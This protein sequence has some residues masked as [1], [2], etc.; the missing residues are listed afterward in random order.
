MSIRKRLVSSML[1]LACGLSTIALPIGEGLLVSAVSIDDA[2]S[3]T[4]EDIKATQ[5]FLMNYGY[6]GLGNVKDMNGDGVVNVIDLSL[7]KRAYLNSGAVTLSHFW[8]DRTDIYLDGETTVTFTVEVTSSNPLGNDAVA[9]YDENDDFIA[10]M[11]DD[12]EN[13]DWEANDGVYSAQVVVSSS[14]IALVSFY[15]ATAN[16]KSNAYELNFYRDFTDEEVEVFN[17]VNENITDV[18]FEDAKK[19]IESSSDVGGYAISEDS[20]LIYYVTT[21]GIPG[22][23]CNFSGWTAG[24]SSSNNAAD[25]NI[26]SMASSEA[27]AE[28]SLERKTVNEF[29]SYELNQNYA[30]INNDAINVQLE[31]LKTQVKATIDE[32]KDEEKHV[33]NAFRPAH[34]DKTGVFVFRP[35]RGEESAGMARDE[36]KFA[37]EMISYAFTGDESCDV[38]DDGDA[39]LDTL[40]TL[41]FHNYGTI[42]IE[43]HGTYLDGDYDT[44]KDIGW[45]I[46][47]NNMPNPI[48]QIQEK[49]FQYKNRFYNKIIPAGTDAFVCHGGS[50]ISESADILAGRVIPS[51]SGG[52]Q[53]YLV[54]GK[55]FSNNSECFSK[56]CFDETFWFLGYCDSMKK[57]GNDKTNAGIQKVNGY[58]DYMKAYGKPVHIGTEI[59]HLGAQCI[60]GYNETVNIAYR[61]KTM[62]EFVV[63][64]LLLKADSAKKSYESVG[65]TLGLID[66]YEAKN[67]NSCKFVLQG[68]PEYRLVN[69]YTIIYGRVHEQYSDEPAFE[70]MSRAARPNNYFMADASVDLYQYLPD[71]TPVRED[72]NPHYDNIVDEGTTY[73]WVSADAENRQYYAFEVPIGKVMDDGD[74]S[75]YHYTAD[76]KVSA[77]PDTMLTI[78]DSYSIR[79]SPNGLNEYQ[80]TPKSYEYIKPTKETGARVVAKLPFVV[81]ALHHRILNNGGAIGGNIDS[82]F[83]DVP[84]IGIDV[85]GVAGCD[86]GD[87]K[88]GEE[89]SGRGKPAQAYTLFVPGAYDVVD[90]NV[91]GI[92]SARIEVDDIN[93]KGIQWECVNNKSSISATGNGIVSAGKVTA[94]DVT[95]RAENNVVGWHGGSNSEEES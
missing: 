54:T 27:H 9:V 26:V 52:H 82:K 53:R 63:N 38:Y 39:S 2:P 15:A 35:Y 60:A 81:G 71:D 59:E 74:Y 5:A 50:I 33:C 1:A 76:F 10:Y 31:T 86:L 58:D 29:V 62:L 45:N 14:D 21:S 44:V 13:G 83:L 69:P 89:V 25:A 70:L 94:V 17:T 16:V 85:L 7:A 66:P 20:E 18:S 22:V 78:D 23:W 41:G 87:I 88:K 84:G 93:W 67:G 72:G 95:A 51:Y 36:F 3:T 91:L 77:G 11:H 49:E 28:K 48:V 43:T 57:A 12:G 37:G 42:M 65:N 80:D 75:L 8:A 34:P 6:S 90:C 47:D 68:S 30:I 46:W 40:K 19:Y 92:G 73:D 24:L 4:I 56:N 79:L 55:F 61:N 64:G 32:E